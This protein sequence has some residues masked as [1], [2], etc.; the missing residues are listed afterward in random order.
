MHRWNFRG[1]DTNTIGFCAGE[2][3]AR[4]QIERRN[5]L[6]SSRY[7]EFFFALLVATSLGRFDPA[8][9]PIQA[10]GLTFNQLVFYAISV[11]FALMS[12]GFLPLPKLYGAFGLSIL[13]LLIWS[14]LSASW[15]EAA[16]TSLAKATSYAFVYFSAIYFA[17]Q[18]S[19]QQ[20]L[21]SSLKAALVV[22]L[23]SVILAI[24]LPNSAGTT[25]FH[26]GAWR[27]VFMQKNVLGRAAL[28]LALLAY[29]ML[30]SKVAKDNQRLAYF[31]FA[32]AL[33]TL[34]KST[35]VTAMGVLGIVMLSLPI[36]MKL[37]D[38]NPLARYYFVFLFIMV[39][40]FSILI[41]DTALAS[42]AEATGKSIT[43]TGRI[44]LWAFSLEQ[45]SQQP[46]IGFGLE[47]YFGTYI[48]YSFFAVEGWFAEHAH[49]GFIDLALELG[50]VGLALFCV[51][52]IWFNMMI[53]RQSSAPDATILGCFMALIALLLIFMNLTESNLYRSSNTLWFLY[54][55]LGIQAATTT[56]RNKTP[57]PSGALS[58]EVKQ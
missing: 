55:T 10:G 16:I 57:Q 21:R 12:F 7:D 49:N 1:H 38:L 56:Y 23:I 17:L 19:T 46:M 36:V 8:F 52:F 32:V 31:A 35:S 41:A 42:F 29:V 3:S 37:R 2:K 47:G 22:V 34:I 25:T 20:L 39:A 50:I 5:Q 13:L 58:F 18:L 11:F 44:P 30:V 53:L 24:L 48:D 40:P 27:G 26:E 43:L 9:V 15:S 14:V 51:S 45:L 6:R 4:N 33:L 28:I 54:L